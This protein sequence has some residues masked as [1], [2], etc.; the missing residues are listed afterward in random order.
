MR[1]SDGNSML[2][3]EGGLRAARSSIGVMGALGTA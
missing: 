2:D 3:D 1:T